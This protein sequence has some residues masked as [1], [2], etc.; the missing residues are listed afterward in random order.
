MEKSIPRVKYYGETLG[1]DCFWPI[2]NLSLKVGIIL[3]SPDFVEWG[4]MNSSRAS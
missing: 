1:V 3:T 4:C 2:K